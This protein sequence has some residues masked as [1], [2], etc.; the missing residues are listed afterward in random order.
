VDPSKIPPSDQSID[1]LH[2][3]HGTLRTRGWL[4]DISLLGSLH[5]SKNLQALLIDNLQRVLSRNIVMPSALDDLQVAGYAPSL[6][7]L[8]QANHSIG[9]IGDLFFLAQR[10]RSVSDLERHYHSKIFSR[11]S[12]RKLLQ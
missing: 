4:R 9:K 3:G 5:P 12:L 11:E 10:L 6:V 8:S 1:R 2:T 7:R